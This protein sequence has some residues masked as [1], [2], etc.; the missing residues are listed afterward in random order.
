LGKFSHLYPLRLELQAAS[1]AASAKAFT[2]P[3]YAKPARSKATFSR[4]P[5]FSAMRLI[6]VAAATLPPLPAAPIANALRLLQEAEAST[7]VPSS[8]TTEA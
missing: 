5:A 6:S 3:W 1:R 8:E 2:R 4:Q 7:L